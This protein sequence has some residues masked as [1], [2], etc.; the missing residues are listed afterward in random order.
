MADRFVIS[1]V[2]RYDGEYDFDIDADPLTTREWHWIKKLSGYMPM[3]L[4]E[5]LDGGDPS[6]VVALCTVALH[7]A[8]KISRDEVL[9]VADSLADAPFDGAAIQLVGDGGEQSPPA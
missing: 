6:L 5:G 4:G 9:P 1:G 7:R 3:T 2:G 8:G